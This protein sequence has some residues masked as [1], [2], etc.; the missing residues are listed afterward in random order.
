MCG[1][2]LPSGSVSVKSS[3]RLRESQRLSAHQSA[4]PQL[5]PDRSAQC[6][7]NPIRLAGPAGRRKRIR[8]FSSRFTIHEI[9]KPMIGFDRSAF[10]ASPDWS[11][12][13]NQNVNRVNVRLI[14]KDFR[15]IP[16]KTRNRQVYHSPLVLITRDESYQTLLRRRKSP[17]PLSGVLH[18]PG[19]VFI[20]SFSP[21]SLCGHPLL[22]AAFSGQNS[23]QRSRERS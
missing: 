12:F 14:T 18:W 16:S 10:A 15:S 6:A 5:Y 3:S 22:E 19:S 17:A 11:G 2:A 7:S 4:K 23:T 1:K 13:G 8:S 21:L 9:T 20:F